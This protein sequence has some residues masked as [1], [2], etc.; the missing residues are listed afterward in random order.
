MDARLLDTQSD[1]RSSTTGGVSAA[2]E[3][4]QATVV[5][6]AVRPRLI[7][8]A[9]KILGS[10]AETEDVVQ[11]AWLRWQ[12][13]DRSTV[14]SPTAFLATTT[15]RLALN[16]AQSARS[17]HETCTGSPWLL[18]R[19]D[20]R[21]GPETRAERGEAIE[22]AVLL[23]LRNLT[24]AERA[25]Y[26]LR[27]AFGYPY[28]RIAEILLLTAAHARQLVRRAHQRLATQRRRPVS[29][30]AHRRLV[31]AFNAAAQAGNLTDLERL[32]VADVAR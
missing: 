24:P 27:E 16:L 20:P 3:L 31:L 21:I 11:E 29:P 30:A 23:L 19:A 7:D 1:S 13:T 2:G 15:T 5:F 6:A 32:L 9:Y 17:R 18:E 26:V 10:V 14:L 22:H 8:I 25:A 12:R 28:Q 4:E